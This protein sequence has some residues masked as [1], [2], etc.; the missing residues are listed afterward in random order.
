M[1]RPAF[2]RAERGR[3]LALLSEPFS[4]QVF[5]RELPPLGALAV[6]PEILAAAEGLVD[7]SDGPALERGTLQLLVRLVVSLDR[8]ASALPQ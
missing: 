8:A 6:R 4:F 5:E 1:D 7:S 2:G 3:V